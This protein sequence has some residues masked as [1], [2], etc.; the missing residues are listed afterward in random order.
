MYTWIHE[1]CQR[2]PTLSSNA[3][4]YA[5]TGYPY[6]VHPFSREGNLC[7]IAI[8]AG[9]NMDKILNCLLPVTMPHSTNVIITIYLFNFSIPCCS[10]FFSYLWK[11]I[12]NEGKAVYGKHVGIFLMFFVFHTKFIFPCMQRDF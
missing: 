10:V 6:T 2:A 8:G 9:T 12:F 7:C 1:Q 3:T 11:E 4:F 5:W